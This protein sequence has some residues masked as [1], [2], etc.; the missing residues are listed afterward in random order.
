MGLRS[1][2]THSP[3]ARNQPTTGI[4]MRASTRSSR[5]PQT[6]M[7]PVNEVRRCL[8]GP[9][10]CRGL[11]TEGSAADGPDADGRVVN[12]API[13][14]PRNGPPAH[15]P[16]VG[17]PEDEPKADKHGGNKAEGRTAKMA[18]LFSLM[19]PHVSALGPMISAME[20]GSTLSL[21]C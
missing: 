2:H 9:E 13:H 5:R 12:V 21:S 15:I 6:I 11:T 4:S 17:E 16:L 3:A 7:G 8:Y 10:G 1:R 14:S 19:T 20:T 18:S